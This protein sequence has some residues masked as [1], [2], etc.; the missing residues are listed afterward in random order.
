MMLSARK[1]CFS[2]LICLFSLLFFSAGQGMSDSNA[3]LDAIFQ[4]GKK[5][6]FKEL[7]YKFG[8]HPLKF[9]LVLESIQRIENA[10]TEIPFLYENLIN[11]TYLED[12]PHFREL[13]DSK[14]Q[15]SRSRFR[16]EFLKLSRD[17]AG[18]FVESLFQDKSAE[19]TGGRVIPSS[20]KSRL[21]LVL[22]SFQ[23]C[24][25]S[26]NRYN[27]EELFDVRSSELLRLWG[28]EVTRFREAHRFSRGRGVRLA[29]IGSGICEDCDLVTSDRLKLESSFSL[30]GRKQPPWTQEH[31]PVIDESGHGSEIASILMAAAPESDIYIYKTLCDLNPVYPFWPAMLSAQAVYKAVDDGANLI[32]F[33]SVFADDFAFLK[34]ACE[35]AYAN[36]VIVVCPN[37]ISASVDPGKAHHFPAHY[38][39]TVAVAG[40]VPDRTGEP[41]VWPLSG[42]SHYS[43]VA[44]PAGIFSSRVMKGKKSTAAVPDN[45]TAAALTCG[46]VA[47]VSAKIPRSEDDLAG[48]YV[49]RIYEIIT[50]SANPRILGF[51]NFNPKAGY[52]LIDAKKSVDEGLQAYFTKMRRIEANFKKRMAER[53]KREEEA[54]RKKSEKN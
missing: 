35:H 21:D 29:V 44:A 6:F 41:V 8:L 37:G 17:T 28:F 36:N 33:N 52:G 18:L 23:E 16:E 20:G 12:R 39:T 31:K 27:E 50:H 7:R 3:G 1:T 43:S 15:E 13:L 4:E 25:H 10:E 11:I 9:S 42:S 38:V 47:L 48:Q 51:N 5:E 2:L 45:F 26:G 40:I 54:N 30:I 34:K 53:A 46:L 14:S 19:G 49:Q 22:A 32:L 24:D